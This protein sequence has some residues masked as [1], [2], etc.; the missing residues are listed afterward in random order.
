M[1]A[2][3]Y[4][5]HLQIWREPLVSNYQPVSLL[6]IVSKVLECLIYAKLSKFILSHGIVSS[7]QFGFLK[8]LHH[9]ATLSLPGQCP[10]HS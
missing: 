9:T 7:S 2:P 6:C 3:L 10:S 4:N 1:E 8:P 5:P